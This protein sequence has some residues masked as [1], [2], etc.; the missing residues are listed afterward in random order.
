MCLRGGDGRLGYVYGKFSHYEAL[1]SVKIHYDKRLCT[2]K[3]HYVWHKHVGVNISPQSTDYLPSL[4]LI[5]QTNSFHLLEANPPLQGSSNATTSY[6]YL[7][8]GVRDKMGAK[9]C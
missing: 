6:Q 5:I 9:N 1:I 8:L 3:N 4:V 2:V 7:F